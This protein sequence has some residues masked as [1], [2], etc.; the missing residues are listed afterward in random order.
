M[1][2]PIIGIVGR[3]DMTNTDKIIY[4]C[5][6]VRRSII[7]KGGI[8]LLLLPVQDI[9]YDSLDPS[10]VPLLTRLDKDNLKALINLCDGIIIPGGSKWYEYDVF[11]YKYALSRN[12]PILG[13]CLGM[14]MMASTNGESNSILDTTVRNNT[15]INHQQRDK[16]FVHKV[17]ILDGSFLSSLIGKNV[18]YVNSNHNYH[19]SKVDNHFI[20]SG[21]S[22]DGIIEAIEYPNKRFV[23]GVQW[24]PERMLEYDKPANKILDGFISAC[25][26]YNKL[27]E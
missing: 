17:N 26:K 20:I 15:T 13:I 24:H 3:T 6:D 12:I 16:K 14:Q 11:I 22:E 18:I 27:K 8:P 21:L 25:I 10:I 7:K 23:L 2:R 9:Y 5:E 4:V 1:K 19:V